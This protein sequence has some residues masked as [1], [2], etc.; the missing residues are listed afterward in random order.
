MAAAALA[1]RRVPSR[2]QCWALLATGFGFVAANAWWHHQGTGVTGHVVRDLPAA[3]GFALVVAAVAARPPAALSCA[4]LRGLGTISYGLYLWHLP[5]LLWL[6]FQGLLPSTGFVGPWVE[7]A[8]LSVLVA[9]ASWVLVE[10]PVIEAAAR[11]RP[12]SRR[13]P[14]FPADHHFKPLPNVA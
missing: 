8:A 1:H 11:W 4:P 14:T 7:V 9:I 5:V 2:L 12:W 3:A 6:R 13:V 10:R